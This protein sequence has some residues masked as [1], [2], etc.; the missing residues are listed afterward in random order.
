MHLYNDN[1]M[2]NLKNNILILCCSFLIALSSCESALKDYYQVSKQSGEKNLME[3]IESQEDL[4]DFTRILHL[5]GYDTIISN[6]QTYTVWAPTND[7]LTGVD[8]SN[9]ALNLEIVKSHIARFSFSVADVS[10]ERVFA[11]SQ[12]YLVFK[13]TLNGYLYGGKNIIENEI[14]AS[15]GLLHKIDEFVPFVSNIWEYLPRIKDADLGEGNGLDSIAKYFYSFENKIFN[16]SA[17]KMIGTNSDNK[18]VYDSVFTITNNL[19][20]QIGYI[21][22]ED[23]TYTMI[24]PNNKAWNLAFNKI[25]P[26]YRLLKSSKS[27]SITNIYVKTK[28]T[29]DLVF[30]G[31]QNAPEN[32]DSLISTTGDVFYNPGYLF[33]GVQKINL[34][35]GLVYL[36]D[37][38]KYHPWD[39]WQQEIRLEAEDGTNRTN[40]VSNV[41]VRSSAG[42]RFVDI[43]NN[44][45]LEVVPTSPVLKPS[46]TFAIPNTLSAEYNIYCAFVPANVNNKEAVN[47]ST[48]VT[49][50]IGYIH[51]GATTIKT[52]NLTLPAGSNLT[53]PT[54]ITKMLVAKNFKF[55]YANYNEKI[56]TVTLKVT[57]DV[58]RNE[59]TKFSQT[60]RIDCIILE[61][62][63]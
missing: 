35:N 44:R 52:E 45:Y 26:Y 2:I 9:E 53:K 6:S 15:N 5:T 21:N 29:R 20:R 27:D 8:T 31:I 39:S 24:I 11:L 51:E 56:T 40:S 43:S 57:N 13:H 60:M 46:V 17:S 62:V 4:S 42:S 23:S 18:P 10:E 3:I 54:I 1:N 63:H 61:P 49:F 22:N 50:T 30:R 37:S 33:N 36:S 34:S 12:K 38:L 19:Y 59:T 25:K 47:D 48:R 28:L 32:L 7:A 58:S 55:P 41:S 16:G 14:L